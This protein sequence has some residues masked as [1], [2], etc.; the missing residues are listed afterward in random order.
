MKK[1]DIVK[2]TIEDMS[3]EGQGIGRSEGMVVFTEGGIPGDIVSARVTKVKKNFAFARV[4]EVL[5]QS[6]LHNEEFDCPYHEMG[7]G[8]CPM[9]K[10]DYQAQLRIKE[11]HVRNRLEKI[12]GLSDPVIHSIIGME[13]EDNRG[14]GCWR[15]RNKAVFP[16]STG[17]IITKKGGIVEGLSEP[18]V[19]FYRARSH[20]VVN[21]GDCYLQSMAAM[22]A[23]DA[24]R[25]FMQEDNITGY[26]PKWEKGLLRQMTVKI[27][28]AT[29][30]VMVILAINGNGIPGA[31]KLVAMLD[32]AIS[33]VGHSLESVVLNIQK[34]AGGKNSKGSLKD[35]YVTIAGKP[36]IND[37]LGD[38]EFEI[39]P[40][41][42][43]QVNPVQMKRLYDK[44]REYVA[45]ICEKMDRGDDEHQGSER[46][47]EDRHGKKKPVVLDLYC[48]IGSI[49]L[50]CSDKA[51]M[52]IGVESVKDAVTDANRNSVIN[53]IV[54]TRYLWGRAEEILPEAVAGKEDGARPTDTGDTEKGSIDPE[55]RQWIR[56]ADVAIIDPPRAGCGERLLD[57]VALAEIPN[58]IYV[59]CDPATLAR[60]IKILAEQGYHFIEATPLDMFP[61]TLHVEAVTLLSRGK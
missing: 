27:A 40:A 35:R 50:Y 3:V 16:V 24:L 11:N 20:E 44:V 39:S 8:G 47:N 53:H 26:D 10:L 28:F 56:K 18:A 41:S 58:I 34:A 55:I 43:C 15:Y 60:D 21:C 22:A 54:N 46:G 45:G 31:Q 48:G 52:V 61:N 12:A 42:F 51:E 14:Q 19:G 33:Q 1:D 30:E 36:V 32:E 29:G 17:G 37:R 6:P 49:G 57:A 59:S 9:G 4:E 23:A 5:E 38:L 25:R 13:D 7:C 2:L